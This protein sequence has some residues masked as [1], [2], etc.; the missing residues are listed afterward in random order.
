MILV[1][2]LKKGS[3]IIKFVCLIVCF[4]MIKREFGEWRVELSGRVSGWKFVV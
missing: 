3:D 2:I 1:E 4:K